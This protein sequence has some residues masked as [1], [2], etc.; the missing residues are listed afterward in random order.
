MVEAKGI[1]APS[2][3]LI[4]LVGA[5]A[6]LVR[7]SRVVTGAVIFGTLLREQ[8]R[9]IAQQGMDITLVSSLGPVLEKIAKSSRL[10]YHPVPMARKPDKYWSRIF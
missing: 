4:K 10:S 7:I 3:A 6:R 8:L 1:A 9:Y 5:F 2:S